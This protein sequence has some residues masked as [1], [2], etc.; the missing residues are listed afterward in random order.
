[1][2]AMASIMDTMV[3]TPENLV[4]SSARNNRT[5]GHRYTSEERDKAM[6][7]IENTPSD[8]ESLYALLSPYFRQKIRPAKKKNTKPKLKKKLAGLGPSRFSKR[9]S[10]RRQKQPI[11][12]CR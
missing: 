5:I 8:D 1:M 9:L 10:P 12:Y 7:D 3:S 11:T 4:V 2:S 6:A